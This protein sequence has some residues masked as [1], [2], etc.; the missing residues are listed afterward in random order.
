MITEATLRMARYYPELIPDTAVSSIPVANNEVVPPILDLR[1][2]SP[3]FLRLINIATERDDDVQ[4]F[5][6]AD[7]TREAIVAGSLIGDYAGVLG[8]VAPNRFDVLGTEN[9]YFNLFSSAIEVNLRTFFGV[10]VYKP[11]VA[12]K[13]K[14]GMTLTPDERRL[15]E[16]LGIANTVEKGLLPLPL[17]LQIE[18]E[19]QVIE[20]VTRGRILTVPAAPGTVVDTIHSRINEC[21]I[22]TK[23]ATDPNVTVVL[24]IDRDDDAAYVAAINTFPLSLD[25]DLNCFMPA[26]KEIRIS[27][28][29]AAP[30]ANFN[31]R[32]TILR[33]KMN[34]ILRARWNLVT[35][36]ELP[37]DVYQKVKG[38]VL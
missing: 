25:F 20:E 26:T 14:A 19:Y 21:I 35:P 31:I 23:I 18:R 9:L 6:R 1:R 10:W 38:G 2:F 30:V 37:G 33:C 17:S 7:K 8:G 34:N 36:D 11:T 27:L 15:S 32:Y 24:I 13:L 3:L 29:A 5:I 4:L 12:D 16:E 28:L 22:L